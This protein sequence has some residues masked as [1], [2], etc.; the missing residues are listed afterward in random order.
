M[1]APPAY[2]EP[3]VLHH[4]ALAARGRK[5]VV[6]KVGKGALQVEHGRPLL[7][8]LDDIGA[9]AGLLLPA[10]GQLLRVRIGGMEVEGDRPDVWLLLRRQA[11]IPDGVL[12]DPVDGHIEADIAGGGI[13]DVL[14]DQVVGVPPNGVVPLP[15]PVQA[16]ENQVGL[17]QVQGKGAVGHHVHN[18]KAQRPG[19]DNQL[20]QS[21]LSVPPEEGL[22]AAEKQDAHPHL[23]QAGHLLPDLPV[24]MDHV[25]DVVHRTVLA[26]QIALVRQDNRAQNGVLLP[27]QDGFYAEPGQMDKR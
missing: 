5:S 15:V 8:H 26:V 27:E 16:E 10:Q 7:H 1:D 3:A 4:H 6:N 21:L 11:H 2:A 9:A 22:A 23:I 12:V 17:R 20:P 18:E 14:Q 25:G 19:F 24:G 13:A